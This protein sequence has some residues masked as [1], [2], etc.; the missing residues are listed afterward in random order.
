MICHLPVLRSIKLT[1]NMRAPGIIFDYRLLSEKINMLCKQ[2]NWYTLIP[3]NSPYLIIEEDTE[4]YQITF[5][6]K[7]MWLLKTD[8]V[9]L[10]LENITLETLSQWFVDQLT[11]EETFITSY[12][13]KDLV[14]KVSNGP[15]HSAES[16]YNAICV[17]KL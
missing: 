7:S 6:E 1:A 2:L 8:V 16:T 9:L 3:T 17:K 10:P 12:D 5:N 11:L 4:H 15:L 14:V 13:I